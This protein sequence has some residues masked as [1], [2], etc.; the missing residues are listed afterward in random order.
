MTSLEDDILQ[1]E[2]GGA[3][4][5]LSGTQGDLSVTLLTAHNPAQ[6]ERTISMECYVFGRKQTLRVQAQ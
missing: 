4:V 1:L 5:L 3:N 6:Q 2:N